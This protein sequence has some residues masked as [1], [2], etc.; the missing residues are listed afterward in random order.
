MDMRRATFT[1][2]AD[3][4]YAA[5]LALDAGTGGWFPE[6]WTLDGPEPYAVPLP[7]GQP[8][9]PD[10]EVLP[11][12][13]GRV[14]I[15]RRVAERH[16]LALLYP[17]GPSTGELPLGA[18]ECR[19]LSLL[20]PS[21]CGIRAF[22]LAHG[23][24]STALWLLH[25]GRFGPERVVEVPGRCSGGAW[26]DRSGRLLALDRELDGRT[27]A[28]VV[29]LGR[30]A[31]TSPLLQITEES[32]DRL[33]LAD[34]D[35]GLL[36][37]RSDAPGHERLGWG[38]L[39]SARPVRFPECLCPPGAALTPFA[40]QP[41]QDLTPEA[42]AVAFRIVG[43]S[44][45]W[46][47]VW[48]PAG[49]QLQQFPG[50]AGWLVGT[51]VWTASGELRLPYVTPYVRCGLARLR[52]PDAGRAPGAPPPPS[53]PPARDPL[54]PIGRQLLADR[55]PL[56]PESGGV[57]L[58]GQQAA[59]TEG[60]REESTDQG[61]APQLRPGQPLLPTDGQ[62]SADMPPGPGAPAQANGD[63]HPGTP[64]RAQPPQPPYASVPPGTTDTPPGGSGSAT[65][66]HHP[67]PPLSPTDRHAN[68]DTHPDTP[69]R[70]QSPQPPYATVPPG[71]TDTPPGGSGSATRQHHP[72]PPL[73]PTD[74]H[75]NGDTHP[76][77]PVRA[78]S[79][80]PPYA[81]ATPGSAD[82]PLLEPCQLP[83]EREPLRAPGVAGPIPMPPAGQGRPPEPAPAAASGTGGSPIAMPPAPVSTGDCPP[84]LPR[85]GTGPV[86][87][88]RPA[89]DST[90]T[91]A[92]AAP[93]ADGPAP[94]L[95]SAREPLL[96]PV[97]AGAAPMP[98]AGFSPSS[99]P[100]PAHRT[101][102]DQA[103]PES[104]ENTRQPLSV[105]RPLTITAHATAQSAP[106]PAT[107]PPPNTPAPGGGSPVPTPAAAPPL[108]ADPT[109][110][111]GS[112]PPPGYSNPAAPS[113]DQAPPGTP[114][115]GHS[116][117]APTGGSPATTPAATPPPSGHAPTAH[118]PTHP[119]P[120]PPGSNPPPGYS[121]PAAPSPDQAP[122][123]HSPGTPTPGNNGPA[124]TPNTPAPGGGSPATTPAATAPPS[125]HAPTAHPPTHPAPQPP[126]SNPP[127]G[128]SNPAAPSP[129]QA[130][131]V[132]PPG[133]PTP[134]NN[135]PAPGGGSPATTPDGAT[136]PPSGH[137]HTAH[138]PTNPAPH[139]S[140]PASTLPA[141]PT[142]SPGPLPAPHNPPPGYSN[143]AAPSPDQAPP[144]TPAPTPAPPA[145]PAPART[146]VPHSPG[147]QPPGNGA[148]PTG[149]TP[150]YP[151]APRAGQAPPTASPLGHAPAPCPSGTPPF[152]DN[153]PAQA[154]PTPPPG[155]PVLP[156]GLTPGTAGSQVVVPVAGRFS[157]GAST[158]SP[159]G[160]RHPAAPARPGGRMQGF[161]GDPA[162][163]T[164]TA[165]AGTVADTAASAASGMAVHTATASA[166]SGNGGGFRPGGRMQGFFIDDA[167]DDA[168]DDE[169]DDDLADHAPTVTAPTVTAPAGFVTVPAQGPPPPDGPPPGFPPAPPGVPART[170]TLSAGVWTAVHPAAP[171]GGPA[172]MP[173]AWSSSTSGYWREPEAGGQVEGPGARPVPLQ[174]A[175]IAR[176]TPH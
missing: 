152:G 75:A 167:P 162:P 126:G 112:N 30:G 98:T 132:H 47:G 66:Q 106:A 153:R 97:Q 76:D 100:D 109:P 25:G 129:D 93:S 22:G 59:P 148:P 121:N 105:T 26:L 159:G 145:A 155:H 2:T 58:P 35:S 56:P 141:D 101:R 176:D 166:D 169:P 172:A 140:A 10:S 7:G 82:T 99:P 21:P 13:D 3:G 133:T 171:P 157:G 60:L 45:S 44:G 33:L 124:Q 128:Y 91:T 103:S 67:E 80:Q 125:G 31:E 150:G 49:R 144:G 142:P 72:E 160:A 18:V 95:P 130:L 168:P 170:P 96:P 37:V 54:P 65:R 11:L 83:P 143:P 74:R 43:P 120:Q 62:T 86:P 51:G 12:A 8:E 107:A 1:V 40:A 146:P 108:P 151:Q 5:R 164:A 48:R 4:S 78:Q 88:P 27:K 161:L 111:P 114:A 46:V 117:P 94:Q 19:H 174:Q 16:T 50:P 53:T 135:G 20:P 29:D 85:P 138:P 70:A 24:R 115:P 79:P 149:R 39:G 134:G 113:P 34:P 118:P 73:S 165:P 154:A 175:P 42:S 137:A 123:A 23:E 71:T 92:T 77:T 41:G 116:G 6:R 61:A 69:V 104:A 158:A 15:R 64:V 9:E 84:G 63:T 14:L 173:G 28:V 110:S 81:T 32:N 38:V 139:G 127:P 52:L 87:P 17:T 102:P 147:T 68:G 90:S 136:A 156:G 55:A 122:T 57:T 119:A 163:A 89:E 131:A 36:L